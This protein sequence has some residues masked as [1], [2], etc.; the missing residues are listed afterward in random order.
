MLKYWGEMADKGTDCFREAYEKGNDDF[1]P[2]NSP[3][4][5]GYCHAWSCTP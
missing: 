4:I 5:N 1:S 3:A 2:Y